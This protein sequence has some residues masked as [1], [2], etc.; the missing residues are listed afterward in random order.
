MCLFLTFFVRLIFLIPVVV[1]ADWSV[2]GLSSHSIESPTEAGNFNQA[3]RFDDGFGLEFIVDT[4]PDCDPD[5]IPFTGKLRARTNVCTPKTTD[6]GDGN[7]PKVD[8]GANSDSNV[9]NGN[10]E[11]EG[12]NPAID[13]KPLISPP[14]P[15]VRPRPPKPSKLCPAPKTGEGPYIIVCHEGPDKEIHWDGKWIENGKWC[16]LNLFIFLCWRGN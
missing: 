15:V 4:N 14:V 9:N 16:M 3:S 10:G 13:P 11:G 5:H 7:E 6:T 8:E 2:D 12:H 1:I